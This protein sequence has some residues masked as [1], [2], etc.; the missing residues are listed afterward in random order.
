MAK[1]SGSTRTIT[2]GVT[3]VAAAHSEYVKEMG[4]GRY[5]LSQSYFSEESGGSVLVYK[6][7]TPDADEM[8][9]AK[10]MANDGLTVKITPEGKIEF[11]SGLN[12][13]DNPVY[14][15]G[16]VNG[17]TYEQSSKNPTPPDIETRTKAADRALKHAY[18]K[19]A[20]IP[21]IY[22]KFGKFHRSDIEAGIKRFEDKMKS[23]R[24]KTILVV[25][26]RGNVWEHRHN[27]T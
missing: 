3:S 22:D 19:R 14:A 24:F 11:S 5:D 9:A 23:H 17:F 6:G 7:R 4:S 8:F 2:S 16:L 10:A 13:K 21:L 15:D 27:D 18:D 26:R 20:S 12:P 1:A 25:D